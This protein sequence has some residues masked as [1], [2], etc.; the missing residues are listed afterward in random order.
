MTN[1]SDV[2]GKVSEGPDGHLPGLAFHGTLILAT[3][4]FFAIFLFVPIP[5]L[6]ENLAD[7]AGYYLQIASN[8]AHGKWLT[9]DGVNPTNGFHPMWMIVL[10]PLFKA[11]ETTPESYFRLAGIMVV[12]FLALASFLFHR[13]LLRVLHPLAASV[14]GACFLVFAFANINLMESAIFLFFFACLLLLGLGSVASDRMTSA[15]AFCFGLLLGGVILCRLDAAFLALALGGA[16]LLQISREVEKRGPLRVLALVVLGACLVVLPYLLFNY[17]SFG[18][19]VPVSGR[20]E[21]TFPHTNFQTFIE[22]LNWLGKLRLAIL[23]IACVYWAARIAVRLGWSPRVTPVSRPILFSLDVLA[24]AT[25][26]HALNEVLFVRWRLYWHFVLLIPLLSLLVAAAWS[27][28][29][30]RIPAFLRNGVMLV[31]CLAIGLEGA[32]AIHRVISREAS[33]GWRAATYEASLW[34]RANTMESDRVA[35]PT[36]EIVGFFSGRGVVDLSG[37]ANDMGI[38]E[39]MSNQALGPYLRASGVRYI[40]LSSASPP[41][42]SMEDVAL[43][44]FFDSDYFHTRSEPLRVSRVDEVYRSPVISGKENMPGAFTLWRWR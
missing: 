5:T 24:A 28:Y 25:L 3:S 10:V 43:E 22:G 18:S 15:R 33:H 13:A 7:G 29:W 4:V 20:L 44:F 30:P 1:V 31:V 38:Q 37:L 12:G 19:P 40:F 23:T 26:V 34:I 27:F 36:P 14:A 17:V 16:G 32:F 41:S 21:S 9:F 11:V 35:A 39:A 6:L 8:A 2:A 42:A